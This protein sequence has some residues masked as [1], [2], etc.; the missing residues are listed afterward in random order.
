MDGQVV[1]EDDVATP[2]PWH[3]SVADEAQE[4][5][6]VHRASVCHQLGSRADA[7]GTKE[8]DGFPPA[9]GFGAE[10]PLAP[11]GTSEL[12]AHA[13]GAIGLVE[14]DEPAHLE[15]R[16]Q[17]AEEPAA[18]SI[19]R[20]VPLC[21][22]EGLFFR[23][24]PSRRNFLSTEERLVFT[25]VRTWSFSVSSSMVAS[26]M[27]RTISPSRRATRP[28]SGEKLPPPFGR[29]FNEPV[30]RWRRSIRLT[31]A[32]PTFNSAA[33]RSYERCS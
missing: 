21:R 26:G 10:G 30:S 31:V 13:G 6:S 24:Y 18:G 25:P 5:A 20:E 32:S 12:S 17:C 27:E 3:E 9:K 15:E 22:A 33:M 14:E 19:E 28:C 11:A 7:N 16:Y 23:E 1:H 4:N 29:G 8:R 2:Q